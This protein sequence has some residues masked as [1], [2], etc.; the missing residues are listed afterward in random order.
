MEKGPAE[1]HNKWYDFGSIKIG[2]AMYLVS[3]NVPESAV[4]SGET[5][6]T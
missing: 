5:H 4:L 3:V 6:E 1:G 2:T